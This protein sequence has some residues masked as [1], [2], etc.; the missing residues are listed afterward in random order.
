[1]QGEDDDEL[2]LSA[3]TVMS[4]SLHSYTIYFFPSIPGNSWFI[5][6][7]AILASKGLSQE[8]QNALQS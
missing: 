1:M 5:L 7:L 3:Q 6:V 2:R 8:I 4:L